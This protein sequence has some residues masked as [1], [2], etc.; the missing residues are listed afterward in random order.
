MLLNADAPTIEG[1]DALVLRSPDGRLEAAF[2]PR[3]G[4]VLASLRHDGEEV[5]GQRDGVARYA[6]GGTTMGVPLLHPWANRLA[7]D[8]Y[9]V[10][11]R[12]VMLRDSRWLGRDERGLPIHGVAGGIPWWD[13]ARLDA[14][15]LRA[16]L[17]FG[18]HDELLGAFPFPHRLTV[19]AYVNDGMLTLRTTLEPSGPVAVPVAFGFHPYLRLPG[20]PR[21]RWRVALP[22]L[23]RL[24]L[25]A[26]GLPTGRSSPQAAWSGALGDRVLDDAFA[27]ARPGSAFG[28]AGGGRSITV[29]FGEGYAFAQ[30]YAPADDDVVCFEPMTAPTNALITGDGLTV[31]G[32]GDAYRAAFSITVD[33]DVA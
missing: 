8:R 5:L 32:P 1:Y 24:E 25:D 17:D 14:G 33:R 28:L 23:R 15:R 2:V 7:G 13:V 21:R 30:L 26:R 22:A 31:V 3:A 9:A 11:A 19:D 12:R 27:A 20:V 29:R 6:Q 4:N 16:E 18:A 10:A